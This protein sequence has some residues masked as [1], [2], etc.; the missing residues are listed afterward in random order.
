M[1]GVVSCKGELMKLAILL[2]SALLATSAAVHAQERRFD[3]SQAKDPK[4]CEERMAKMK[5]THAQAE[6]ACEGKQGAERREC[7]VKSTC[8]QQKDPKACEERTAKAKGMHRDARAA[9]EGKTGAE[10]Q[11]CMVKQLCAE[12]KD[13][14]K[15]EALGKERIA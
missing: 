2:F 12:S 9:C 3:C 6:K 10:H 8:A 7:M 13:G 5:A 1:A 15:C 11:D 14:A 4:A